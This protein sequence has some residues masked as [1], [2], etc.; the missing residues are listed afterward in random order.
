MGILYTFQVNNIYK[1]VTE[2]ISI[3]SVEAAKLDKLYLSLGK[4]QVVFRSHWQ[5]FKLLDGWSRR[6]GLCL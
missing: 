6:N 1:G 3:L 5:E 2:N 4:L